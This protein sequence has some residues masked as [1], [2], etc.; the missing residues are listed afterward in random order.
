MKQINRKIFLKVI[1]FIKNVSEVENNIYNEKRDYLEIYE[2][3]LELEREISERTAQLNDANKRMLTLQ[4]IWAMMNSSTPL[5]N[6][7]EAIVNSTQ[8]ELGYRHCV[9]IKKFKDDKAIVC[10]LAKIGKQNFGSFVEGNLLWNKVDSASIS[11]SGNLANI[12][13]FPTFP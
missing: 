8:G 11:I 2:R 5:E 13:F 9:I 6:V 4:H 3:N 7:L 1:D 12:K 10:G